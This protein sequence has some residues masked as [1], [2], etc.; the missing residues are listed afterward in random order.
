MLNSQCLTFGCKVQ[1][2]T[3]SKHY[4]TQELQA[5]S[6]QSCP[7]HAARRF[8]GPRATGLTEFDSPPSVPL[9]NNFMVYQG[10]SWF[11]MFVY[12]GLSWLIIEEINVYHHFPPWPGNYNFGVSPIFRHIRPTKK[13]PFMQTSALSLHDKGWARFSEL[14]RKHL[15]VGVKIRPPVPLVLCQR[16]STAELFDPTISL[17]TGTAQ[18]LR[19]FGKGHRAGP[20]SALDVNPYYTARVNR[21]DLYNPTIS[22]DVWANQCGPRKVEVG[23]NWQRIE[24]SME[25]A[26]K[27]KT[28]E[29]TT[30]LSWKNLKPLWYLWP[31]QRD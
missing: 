20:Q 13:Q 15:A 31:L 10:L 30:K 27:H 3:A 23:E 21:K 22:F 11:V 28:S 25:L 18:I 5:F 16:M 29:Q 9:Q 8:H 1:Q 7:P 24:Q 14:R 17:R 19:N 12:Q 6:W 26:A 4:A 2:E